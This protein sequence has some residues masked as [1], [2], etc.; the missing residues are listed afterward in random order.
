MPDFFNLMRSS[1]MSLPPHEPTPPS[2]R[3]CRKC[4]PGAMTRHGL[5]YECMLIDKGQKPT[6]RHHPFG[7][8]SHTVDGIVVEI[9]GNWHRALDRRRSERPEILRRPGDNP[10]HQIAAT[11]ATF[12]EAADAV[13][14]VARRQGWPVWVANLADVFAKAAVSATDWLLILAGKLE[15]W[16]GPAWFAEMPRWQP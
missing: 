11:V 2:C 6:E 8:D 9:P 15:E 12:G 16:C 3:R 4:W 5:C 10:L 14:D 7:R 1:I 13:A